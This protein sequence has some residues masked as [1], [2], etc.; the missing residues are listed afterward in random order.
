[1]FQ[2]LEIATL[3]RLLDAAPDDVRRTIESG[4]WT[5]C[6]WPGHSEWEM[7]EACVQVRS[8]AAHYFT[9]RYPEA[10]TRRRDTA[11]QLLASQACPQGGVTHLDMEPLIDHALLWLWALAGGPLAPDAQGEPLA[12]PR[13][14]G[15][16]RLPGSDAVLF[17]QTALAMLEALLFIGDRAAQQVAETFLQTYPDPLAHRAL[18]LVDALARQDTQG[19]LDV[20]I[21]CTDCGAQNLDLWYT[22]KT[23]GDT[24]CMPCYEDRVAR[25]QARPH[26]L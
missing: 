1:M 11:A 25:G 10:E 14:A 2:I 16:I 23:W 19:W 22:G 26:E 8:L 3:M 21:V 9:V 13:P 17:T 15:H 6:L 20:G 18:R 5:G 7:H 12:R 4:E 24:L